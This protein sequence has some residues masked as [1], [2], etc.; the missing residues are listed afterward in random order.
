MPKRRPPYLRE[1]RTK[2][3]RLARTSGRPPA[4]I[5]RGWGLTAETLRIW[6]KQTDLDEGRR[7]EGVTTEERE[8]LRHLR[9][10]NRILC[11]ARASH[12]MRPSSIVGLLLFLKALNRR[13]R[14]IHGHDLVHVLPHPCGPW[15]SKAPRD[16]EQIFHLAHDPP[17]RRFMPPQICP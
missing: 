7:D 12:K 16:H 8:K 1:F 3:I 11:E 14:D 15:Q 9:R 4:E 6:V 5:A 17:R 2:A 10:E 13:F